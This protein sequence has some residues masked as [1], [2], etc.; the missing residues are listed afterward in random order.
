METFETT[1][2]SGKILFVPFESFRKNRSLLFFA[3]II[4]YVY[5]VI[6][7]NINIVLCVVVTQAYNG[8]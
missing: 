6:L 7:G 5:L 4:I 8:C 1:T 2:L 3:H